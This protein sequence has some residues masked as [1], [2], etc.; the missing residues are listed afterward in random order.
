MSQSADGSLTCSTSAISTLTK[1]L[2]TDVNSQ[3]KSTGAS[4]FAQISISESLR[5]GIFVKMVPANLISE[6]GA[7]NFF[8][9]IT[10]SSVF[11]WA[12]FLMEKRPQRLLDIFE[13]IKGIFVKLIEGDFLFNSDCVPPIPLSFLP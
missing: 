8:A 13:E 5:V 1:F 10:F 9:I 2:L 6:F 7:D 12:C 3:F 11:A 4:S